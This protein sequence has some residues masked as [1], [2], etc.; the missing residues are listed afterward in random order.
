VALDRLL[1]DEER[2]RDV[3]VAEPLGSHLGHAALAGGERRDERLL[4]QAVVPD[5]LTGRIFAV[6]DTAQCWAFLPGLVGA[7]LLIPL[8][9]TRTVFLLAGAG[10]GVRAVWC[11][12]W[13]AL[14][15]TWSEHP[16]PAS[17]PAIGPLPARA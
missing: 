2:L 9:G 4:L 1:G 12:T 10:A 15:D 6:K 3:A 11:L 5:R 16:Q 14:R 8:L 7:S 13:L 17:R